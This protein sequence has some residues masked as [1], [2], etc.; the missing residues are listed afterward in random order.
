MIIEALKA[1]ILGLIEG[2]TEFL[3]ISSTGHLLIANQWI[4]F[5]ES[6]TYM[7]DIVIQ[8]GA[9]LAVVIFFWKKLL[10][11]QTNPNER[12]NTLSIWKKVIVAVIPALIIG[13]LLGNIVEQYLFT[14]LVVAISLIIGGII[15]IIVEK[16]TLEPKISSVEELSLGKSFAI[17]C[18]QCLA[19]I[20]GVS[21]SAATIV[22]ARLLGTARVPA[23]EFSF[24]LAIPTLLAAAAY[25]V[26]KYGEPLSHSEYILLA[27]GFVT[28][29][30]VALAVIKFFLSFISKHTFIPFGWYRI[31]LGIII[32]I[33]FFLVSY[34]AP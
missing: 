17:G 27:I 8:L 31:G 15:L 3:P 23:A 6:F 26:W 18:I 30:L 13:F 2:I 24:F 28:A 1:I 33:V 12:K 32:L 29:F 20:P 19:L 5:S 34:P 16:K 21:R 4:S 9:I 10:P 11:I 25:S 14:P 22:G 7:F